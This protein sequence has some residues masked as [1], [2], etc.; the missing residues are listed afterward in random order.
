MFFRFE[1]SLGLLIALALMASG[2]EPKAPLRELKVCADPNNLPFSKRQGEGFENKIASVIGADLG[3]PVRYTWW[4]Q[5][6]GFLR[7]TL[8]FGR[9]DVVLGVPAG[10]AAVLATRPYYRSTYVFVT[11]RDRGL[12]IRSL[13]D[14]VLHSLR[15]G[16]QV[17]GDDHQSSPAAQALARRGLAANVV[18]YSPYG[19]Y[20][21]PNPPADLIDAVADRSVD[22]GIARGPLAGYLA[23]RSPIP[24]KLTPVTPEIDPPATQFAFDIVAGVRRG[25]ASMRD[26]VQGALDRHGTEI[27]DIL[28]SYGVPLLGGGN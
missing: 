16:I 10:F 4:P 6:R 27:R 26:R 28:E 3:L 25:D 18:G 11:R 2:H 21:K 9:C 7:N 22:L 15:I 5:R 19:D 12:H 23:D 20:A 14:S 13:D 17:E 24:L 1:L 8:N